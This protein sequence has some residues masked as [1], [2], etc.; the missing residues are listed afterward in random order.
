MGKPIV[1]DNYYQEREGVLKI[2]LSLNTYGYVFRETPNGDIGIDGQIEHV[3]Y[4][5]EATGK[6]VA[7]QIKSGNSYL[8]DKGDHFAFYPQE[9]HR[10]YWAVFPLPVILFVFYPKDDRIYFTDVKYQL[11]IPKANQ[12]YIKLEKHIYLSD[13]TAKAIFETA[14][15]FDIPY[16]PIDRVFDV[17]ARA[18]CANPTFNISYL[19]LFTQ[20]LTNICRHLYFGMDLAMHIAEYNNETEFGMTIG[21]N[22]HEFLFNY[23][24]FLMSQNLVNIDYSD[25]LID[26]EERKLQPKF[27]AP[28]NPRG[29]EL[30]SFINSI[31]AK[32]KKELPKTTLVRERFI[33]MNFNS[34][35]DILRLE[36]G[37]QLRKKLL[38][39]EA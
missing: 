9:K 34:L 29:T 18:I 1:T 2:A 13:N 36:F 20:G 8:V 6:I 30:L 4:K 37:K 39:N 14:G 15:A 23:A 24:K 38:E 5:G 17:M 35:D 7:T 32:H 33:E 21:T 31:E 10:N 27:Y 22:E 28:I 25:Y 26:W 16:Y 12:T 11:N 19:D 3:N